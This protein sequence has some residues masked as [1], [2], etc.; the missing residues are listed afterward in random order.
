MGWWANPCAERR[1]RRRADQ[2]LPHETLR[3]RRVHRR[4]QSPHRKSHYETE[5]GPRVPRHADTV[6]ALDMRVGGDRNVSRLAARRRADGRGFSVG[7]HETKQGKPSADWVAPALRAQR[8]AAASLV[9]VQRLT[10]TFP[11]ANTQ[12]CSLFVARS[13]PSHPRSVLASGVKSQQRACASAQ[14]AHISFC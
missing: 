8:M 5:D 10:R 4:H 11:P 1:R 7:G 12:I 9:A 2:R 13:Q 14:H 6:F 3:S